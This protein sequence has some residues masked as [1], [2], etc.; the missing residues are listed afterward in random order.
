MP[1]FETT[2][3]ARSRGGYGAFASVALGLTAGCLLGLGFIR[4]F[5]IETMAWDFA[6]SHL[7]AIVAIHSCAY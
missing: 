1:R 7:T 2:P 4:W 3:V 6:C 5:N